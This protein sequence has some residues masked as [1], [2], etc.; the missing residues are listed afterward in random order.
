MKALRW[1]SVSGGLVAVV[2]LTVI[3]VLVLKYARTGIV[4]GDKFRL[5]VAVPDAANL[6]EGSD[7]WLNGQRVGTVAA[8]GFAPPTAP[9]ELRVIVATDVLESMRENIRLDSRASLQSGGTMIGAPVVYLTSGTLAARAVV[10]GDTLR[11]AGKSDFEIAASRVTE[12]L[13]ELPAIMSDAKIIAA[14]ARGA[15]ARLGAI[16]NADRGHG[17]FGDQSRSL[18]TKLTNGNGSAVKL[19]RDQ[20]IRRRVARSMAAA[21][22]LRALLASRMGEFGRF[23]RDSTLARSVSGLRAEIA[24]LRQLSSSP[25]GTVGRFAADSALRRSLDSVFVELSALM[26]DIK[27]NPLRYSRVF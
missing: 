4:R 13:S 18:M 7:V 16:M 14:N 25:T 2:A 20:E 12:S 21:D 19:M 26:A 10:A 5:Y 8:I 23:R 3:L 6:L 1:R 22:S 27:K 15:G 11:G 9:P 24:T 17:S